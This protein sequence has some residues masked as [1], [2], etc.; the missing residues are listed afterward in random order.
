VN[1]VEVQAEGKAIL[2]EQPGVIGAGGNSGFQALN[3]AAQFGANRV[4]LA[5][6]DM[7][8]AAGVH[9]H[10]PHGKNLNN[11]SDLNFVRW[12]EAFAGIV[13][14]LMSAGIEVIN[15]SHDS[16]LAMFQKM[17]IDDALARWDV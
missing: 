12:R 15:A 16:A 9:W 2:L 1:K 13:P 14:T 7:H 11:P 4:I 8:A 5:G 17:S 6:F 3:L 10:G